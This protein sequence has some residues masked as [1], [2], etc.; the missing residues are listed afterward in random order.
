MSGLIF[1]N[2]LI[3]VYHSVIYTTAI[4]IFVRLA[5][6]D[7]YAIFLLL[8][9]T[10]M[11]ESFKLNAAYDMQYIIW[12]WVFRVGLFLNSFLYMF[13]SNIEYDEG[14]NGN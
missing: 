7:V 2:T 8:I 1:C 4:T 11:F 12:Y 6:S 14:Q 3:Y 10:I 9:H 5:P 13:K